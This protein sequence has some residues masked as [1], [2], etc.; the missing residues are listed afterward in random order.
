[1][2]SKNDYTFIK[3]IGRGAFADVHYAINRKTLH[4]YAIK[5]ID[6]TKIKSER[7]RERVREEIK[8][9]SKISR[10]N[11]ENVVMLHVYFEDDDFVYLVLDYC[12]RKDVRHYLRVKESG[13]LSENEGKF[14][15]FVYKSKYIL[16]TFFYC[17]LALK[18]YFSVCIYFLPLCIA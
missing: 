16:G 9:H 15:D 10:I 3:K 1:M 11:H 18:D 5:T 14:C 13:R 17:Y 2:A 12:P 7:M 6:K 4:N 8:I